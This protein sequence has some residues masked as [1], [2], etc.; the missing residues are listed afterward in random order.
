L[1]IGET[2]HRQPNASW[3]TGMNGSYPL[4]HGV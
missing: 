4:R 1:N 3:T 2:S